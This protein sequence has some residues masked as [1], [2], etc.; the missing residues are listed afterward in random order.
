L[1]ADTAAE[2]TL[3]PALFAEAADLAT[4][5]DR[6][7]ELAQHP[8]LTP[9]VAANLAAPAEL[10]REIEARI[11]DTVPMPV[12]AAIALMTHGT[13]TVTYQHYRDLGLRADNPT[14]AAL[15]ANPNTPPDTLLRL[16]GAFPAEFCAN[17]VFPLLLLENPNLPGELPLPTVRSLL[18]YAGVPRGFLEWLVAY[19]LPEVA[20]AAHLHVNLAGEAGGDWA[21]LA[22][23]QIWRLPIAESTELLLELLGLGAVP[24]WMLAAIVA[25]G[26]KTVRQAV[27]RSPHA[28]KGV[29]KPFRRAGASADLA[30]YATP[31]PALHPA[32]LA[33][34]AAGGTYAR[35]LAARHPGT[36]PEQLERLAGD[37]DRVVRQFV[38]K[39]SAASIAAL[40]RLAADAEADVRQMIARNPA[41][42]PA[43]LERL[44]ADAK[45][46]RWNVARHPRTPVEALERLA[47]DAERAVRQA[48]ARNP[49]TP[50]A[51]LE[52]LVA[53][54]HPAVRAMVARNP[55]T[56]DAVRAALL[57]D[58]A[59]AKRS[60]AGPEV[61]P[62]ALSSQLQPA[63]APAIDLENWSSRDVAARARLAATSGLTAA[64]LRQMADDDHPNVRAAVARNPDVSPEL[65]AWLA[66]DD[67]LIVHRAV[68]ENQ[69]TSI[70]LLERF[71]QDYS[72]ANAR[73]RLAVVA[74]PQITPAI[75]ER[76]AGD[77]SVEVRRAVMNHRLTAASA[78]AR[79]LA[80]S[81]DMCTRTSE[82]FY[83]TLA[84]ANPAVP[85]EY[86]EART[87]APEWIERFAI[88]R[89]PRTPRLLLE[90][91]ANDGNRLVR[92]AAHAALTQLRVES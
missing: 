44:A 11:V 90:R 81:L 69:Q 83:H 92:A 75:L 68:A 56:P 18:R 3:A 7:A 13:P 4:P 26:D 48:V 38:G 70:E 10:L 78:R 30:S 55:R 41:T 73:V 52:R 88:A 76:L 31:D 37:P 15:V 59:A 32:E 22:Q 57:A 58:Q 74:H 89:N 61:Q 27:A 20:E 50:P 34:L 66:D 51:L 77:L 8:R 29:L 25:A 43:L 17:P 53:D 86:L 1:D 14:L 49:A 2:R 54:S 47:G 5:A 82:T 21:A 35:K 65:L 46:V 12:A 87:G 9:I 39:N 71:A 91:L 36:P 84:L 72:W 40:T 23:A 64:L 85:P 67:S 80:S 6:L 33:W 42:P 79:I 45:N 60:R 24:D 63:A 28:L 62:A 16:S 19:G